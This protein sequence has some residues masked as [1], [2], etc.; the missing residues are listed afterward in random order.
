M[1]KLSLIFIVI[2]TVILISVIC[3]LPIM[4]L[5]NWLMPDIFNF[6]EITVMQAWGLSFLSCLLFKNTNINKND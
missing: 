4:W 5:W 1:E 3:A 6:P 2:I